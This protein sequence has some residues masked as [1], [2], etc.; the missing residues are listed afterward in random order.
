MT[1]RHEIVE[2]FTFRNGTRSF[3]TANAV[4]DT[5]AHHTCITQA[6]VDALELDA[7]DTA[8]VSS[9]GHEPMLAF[10]YRCLVA[11]TMYEE[12]GFASTHEVLCIP[13][14]GEV[15]IGFDFL[16]AHE[17]SVDIQNQGLVGTAPDGAVP[18]TGGG[19]VL[20]MPRSYLLKLN[21]ER[22]NAAKPGA[23]LRPHPAWRFKLPVFIKK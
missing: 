14:A 6:V 10:I 8:D 13:G 7:Y 2:E 3:T 23:I 22:A 16:R 20:N 11:W 15:L 5:G 9:P 1:I 17:L 4:I 21:G 18:L 12:Q 19:Y